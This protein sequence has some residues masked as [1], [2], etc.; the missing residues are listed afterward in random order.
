[1]DFIVQAAQISR[2]VGKP[3]KLVWSR[4]DDMTHDY[5]RPVGINQLKAGLDAQGNL[6]ALHFKVASQSVTQR[7][8]G[9]AK[10]TLDPF[11]AIRRQLS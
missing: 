7:A 8:F 10:D 11:M 4:E 6:I 2:A 1:L 9:L 3:V 5:Y